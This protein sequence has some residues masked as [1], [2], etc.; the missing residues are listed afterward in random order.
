MTQHQSIP[1]LRDGMKL[2]STTQSRHFI[3]WT[4]RR[5]YLVLLVSN[6]IWSREERE[7]QTRLSF[8]NE[9]G[10]IFHGTAQADLLRFF[11]EKFSPDHQIIYSTHSPFMVPV[12]D[13]TATKI[14]E[15]LVNVNERDRRTLTK[16][17]IRSDV[18]SKD[19]NFVF[20]LQGALG[21]YLT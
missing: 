4:Q 2:Q 13:L 19:R 15:D 1:G 11:T 3:F 18:P 5:I 8:L 12:E 20:P 6:K 21:C 17:R 16:T 10:L 9:P 7:I 14:V